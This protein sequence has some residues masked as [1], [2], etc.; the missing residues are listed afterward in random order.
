MGRFESYLIYGQCP[1]YVGASCTDGTCPIANSLKYEEYGCEVVHNCIECC[2]YHGCS[3]CYIYG[4]CD[5]CSH[6]M[7]GEVSNNYR[8]MHGFPLRRKINNK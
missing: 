3:D 2:F 7:F 4:L 6:I 8:K 5:P 1:N